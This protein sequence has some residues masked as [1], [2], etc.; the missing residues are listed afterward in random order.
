M[1]TKFLDTKVL[2]RFK[3]TMVWF[4]YNYSFSLRVSTDPLLGQLRKTDVPNRMNTGEKGEVGGGHGEKEERGQARQR[5]REME[6]RKANYDREP[7]M[8]QGGK[9]NE[10]EKVQVD[11]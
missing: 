9:D 7:T 1:F 8:I 5:R 11:G 10:Q 2:V 6:T 4:K 3:K